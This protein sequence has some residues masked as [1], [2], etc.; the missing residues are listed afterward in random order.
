MFS[1]DLH[2]KSFIVL[3]HALL[4]IVCLPGC[5]SL[6][7]VLLH[8]YVHAGVRNA[9]VLCFMCAVVYVLFTIL[10]NVFVFIVRSVGYTS[11][12]SVLLHVYVHAVVRNVLAVCLYA[13][14]CYVLLF[15]YD[16]F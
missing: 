8:V 14:C 7:Y 16:P 5:T 13:C 12:V 9:F 4:Y 3:R 6:L 10:R 1:A 11:L 15:I 2:S